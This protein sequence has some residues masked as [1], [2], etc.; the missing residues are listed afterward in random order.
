M[1]N[2]GI[3][4]IAG[5]AAV[6]AAIVIYVFFFLRARKVNLT[7]PE[8]PDQKPEWMGTTPPPETVA[9]AQVDGEGIGLYDHDA[10]E[11]LAAPF[12]EQIEDIIRARLSADPALAA[13]DVDLGTAPD[14]GLEIWVDGARYTDIN[15]LPDER[16]RQVFRQAIE[17]WDARE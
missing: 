5:G 16:L 1:E 7:R 8:S 2:S 6:L 11:R 15:A 13:I 12:A 10:G 14:G 4:W 3:T 17:E 9:A